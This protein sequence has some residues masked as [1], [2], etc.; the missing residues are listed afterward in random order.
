MAHPANKNAVA[1]TTWSWGTDILGTEMMYGEAE[2]GVNIV[3]RENF[4]QALNEELL[5]EIPVT[6]TV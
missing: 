2:S 5:E 3:S 1:R 4:Q 6:P